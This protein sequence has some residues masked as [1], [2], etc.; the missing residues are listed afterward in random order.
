M[1]TAEK[2]LAQVRA[3]DQEAIEAAKKG[4]DGTLLTSQIQAAIHGCPTLKPMLSLA[5]M[6]PPAAVL[7]LGIE[8]GYAIAQ[9]EMMEKEF[10]G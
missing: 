1:I 7:G 2:L 9:A 4:D 6:V 3:K 10:G 5:E 8:L